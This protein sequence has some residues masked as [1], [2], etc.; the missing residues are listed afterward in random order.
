MK[1]TDLTVPGTVMPMAVRKANI[2]TV[3]ANQ[4]EVI[5]IE[6]DGKLFWHGREVVTDDEFRNAVMVILENVFARAIL[7]VDP[8][9]V[10]RLPRHVFLVKTPPRDP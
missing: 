5:R 1:N 7:R 8:I 3:S 4:T 9:R 6:P 10:A 2:L